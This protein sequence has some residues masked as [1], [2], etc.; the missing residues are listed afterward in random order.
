MQRSSPTERCDQ[1]NREM[2]G[3]DT[4]HTT[5]VSQQ[6]LL[7]SRCFNAL[8]AD[9]RDFGRVTGQQGVGRTLQFT[10]RLEF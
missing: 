4:V 10:G 5:V 3:Y 8:V 1:C 9:L 2:A 7:C 6:R